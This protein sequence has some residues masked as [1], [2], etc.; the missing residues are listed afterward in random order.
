MKRVAGFLL[1]F[2]ASFFMLGIFW[3]EDPKAYYLQFIL[4]PIFLFLASKLIIG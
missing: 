1:L 3:T 4:T 2:L